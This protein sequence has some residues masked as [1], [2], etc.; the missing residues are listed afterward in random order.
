[1]AQTAG[2][3]TSY[4]AKWGNEGLG[5]L[6]YST[7]VSKLC[8]RSRNDITSS[9]DVN[10]IAASNICS[11]VEL[12]DSCNAYSKNGLTCETG[13]TVLSAETINLT[14]T[15]SNLLSASPL[16]KLKYA[17]NVELERWEQYH[18]NIYTAG[19]DSE[20]DD[21]NDVSVVN[22][23]DISS[24]ANPKGHYVDYVGG[25]VFEATTKASV[26]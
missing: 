9:N 3:G 7:A 22:S 11:M 5:K 26:S 12:Q 25:K 1:M 15:P 14:T 10:K 6:S 4:L 21:W 23:A 13:A 8:C 19:G 17:L 16:L 2:T 20:H 24:Y 18:A